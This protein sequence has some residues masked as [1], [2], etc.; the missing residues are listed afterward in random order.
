MALKVI[1]KFI[2]GTECFLPFLSKR[3][4]IIFIAITFENLPEIYFGSFWRILPSSLVEISSRV[5]PR[6]TLEI[7]RDSPGFAQNLSCRVLLQFIIFLLLPEIDFGT[8][9]NVLHG[10]IQKI[11]FP[12]GILS[13]FWH[14]FMSDLFQGFLP[15]FFLEHF[16]AFKLAIVLKI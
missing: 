7:L 3:F 9:S 2:P 12:S 5:L 10:I 14:S 16:I 4:E 1:S 13:S 6:I 8:L 11:G 15:D